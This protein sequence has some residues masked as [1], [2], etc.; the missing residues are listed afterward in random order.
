MKH[1]LFSS[2]YGGKIRL[3]SSPLIKYQSIKV[4]MSSYNNNGHNNYSTIIVS[5]STT[6]HFT[7]GEDIILI[8]SLE[9]STT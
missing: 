9:W 7:G 8:F 6:R 1:E 5:S 2:N 4:T 3:A